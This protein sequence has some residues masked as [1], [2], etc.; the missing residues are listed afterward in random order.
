MRL[1]TD[2]KKNFRDYD[3]RQGIFRTITANELLEPE[4]PARVVDVVVERLD[5]ASLYDEYREEGAPAY[6]PKMMLK[7]LF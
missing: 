1:K 2:E 5:L 4:H 7:V 6:R 3:Q